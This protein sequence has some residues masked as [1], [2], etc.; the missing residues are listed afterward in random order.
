MVHDKRELERKYE[1]MELE[2]FQ[3]QEKLSLGT[4]VI[5]LLKADTKI[6][7]EQYFKTPSLGKQQNKRVLEEDGIRCFDLDDQEYNSVMG[8]SD[9][10]RMS[11]GIGQ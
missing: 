3:M 8:E 9:L 11:I 6:Q 5:S 7:N 4:S 10:L 1:A 2:N